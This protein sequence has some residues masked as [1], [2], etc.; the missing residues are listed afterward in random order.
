MFRIFLLFFISV[1]GALSAQQLVH[2]HHITFV[3]SKR[4]A[5]FYTGVDYSI[6]LN[7]W[8]P[9]AGVETGITRT[10]FQQRFNPLVKVG[11][12]YLLVDRA[13]FKLGG[14]AMAYGGML[15]YNKSEHQ[16]Q[17]TQEY[18]GGYMLT[19]GKRIMLYHSM[20]IGSYTESFRS[21]LTGRNSFYTAFN[22]SFNIGITY[23]F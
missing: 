11:C 6:R 19:Y 3:V 2:K 17:F 18:L 21:R 20:M 23:A 8:Q 16:K 4:K 15:T 1:S 14:S 10:F 7:R 12:V 9:V 22:Y 13:A 5:D